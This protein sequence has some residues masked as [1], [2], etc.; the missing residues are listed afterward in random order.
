MQNDYIKE[1]IGEMPSTPSIG[2]FLELW[3]TNNLL[4]AQHQ[5]TLKQYYRSYIKSFGPY[6]KRVY[7]E[8]TKELMDT[9]GHLP[10]PKILE[11]G[12]GCGTEALW[13]ALRGFSVLAID[14]DDSFLGVA[15]ARQELMEQYL[16]RQLPCAFIYKS[17]LELDPAETFDIIFMQ[18]TFHHLE[19]RKEVL[20]KMAQATKQGGYVIISE[21]NFWNPF[22]QLLMFMARGFKTVGELNG[23][24]IGMERLVPAH[25]LN[26]YFLKR[27]FKKISTRYFRT[28]P[29]FKFSDQFEVIDKLTPSWL[30]PMFTHYNI[31]VQKL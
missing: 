4:A 30:R 15:R 10:Q 12:A 24:P 8:Q 6:I 17:I 23:R 16:E 31:V 5:T 9:V 1:T 26:K 22:N 25:T 13:L 28:L 20:D 21:T 27:G 29:N 19:P 7:S 18:Q 2:D 14:I 11:I 3:L